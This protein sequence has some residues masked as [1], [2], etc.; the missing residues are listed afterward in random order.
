MNENYCEKIRLSLEKSRIQHPCDIISLSGG[1]DS[2]IL[3]YLFRPKYA[4]TV[5]Q[6]NFYDDIIFAKNICD[7]FDVKNIPVILNNEEILKIIVNVIQLFCTFDP[8]QIRNNGVIYASIKKA[9]EM[10]HDG[11]VTGDGGDE[12]FAGY[13]YLKRY[14]KNKT[15][16]RNK[17][18]RL[19]KIMD[20]ASVTI[21]NY[22][23]INV[24]SPFATKN[25]I[26]ISKKIPI[27]EL[28]GQRN[29][30]LWGKFILRS[31]FENEIGEDITWREKKAQEI[32][33]G[34]TNIKQY[35]E[36]TKITDL[37]F[38]KEI[39]KFKKEGVNIR[40]KEHLFY[41]R[42]YRKFFPPPKY[43]SCE[44][45]RCPD[46]GGCFKVIGNYCKICGAF[47]IIPVMI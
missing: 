41:Y 7:K 2:S 21:G 23:K 33:S 9:K 12:L 47:P 46:C 28:I 10:N 31:C 34:F 25:L 35:I 20:F 36:E 43:L 18:S 29:G 40:D 32:G 24:I 39:T 8:I 22:F 3:L 4:I 26:E 1:L 27:E 38:E 45:K 6:K 11:I 5:S 30:K 13:N 44:N 16:L 37:F 42:I 17:L 14:Y 19:H 15:K